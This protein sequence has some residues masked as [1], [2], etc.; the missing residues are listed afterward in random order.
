MKL[1]QLSSSILKKIA[2]S[3]WKFF[4]Y[5]NSKR[6]INVGGGPPSSATAPTIPGTGS[7]NIRIRVT[8]GHC[9]ETFVV[10]LV[11]FYWIFYQNVCSQ[12]VNHFMYIYSVEKW[13]N[14]I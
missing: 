1:K 5:F 10:S 6:V 8:C 7:D 14:I 13:S 4:F 2:T 3:P 11:L 9:N 12:N